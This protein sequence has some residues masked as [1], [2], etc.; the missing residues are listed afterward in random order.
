VTHARRPELGSPDDHRERT[1]R[2]LGWSVSGQLAA[3]AVRVGFGVTLARLLSPRD[4]GLLA[5]ILVFS[6]FAIAIADFGLEEALVHRR[7]LRERH[8]SSVFWGAVL[9]GCVLSLVTAAGAPWIAAFY[10]VPDLRGLALLL[11]PFFVLRGIGTVPRA[12]VARRLDFRTIARIDATSATIAGSCA[13]ALAWLGFG[14]VS[15]VVQLLAAAVVES[16][17]VLRTSAWRPRAQLRPAAIRELLG[18]GGWRVATRALGHWSVNVDQLLVGRLLGAGLL[19]AYTR[20]SN[21]VRSP[22]LYVSRPIARAM[23]PS[24]SLI[25]HEPGRVRSAYLRSSGGSAL[26]T[27]PLCLGLFACAEPLVLGV[28]G[29]QWRETVPLVRI[30]SIAGLIQSVT[31]LSSSVFLSQGRPA[32]HLL[33]N[34]FQSVMVVGAVLIGRRWSIEGVAAGYVVANAACAVPTLHVAGRLV[35]FRAGDVLRPLLPVLGSAV[36]M[37]LAVLALGALVGPRL[38]ALVLL[39]IQVAAGAAVYW[40]ALRALG[41]EPYAEV[42][43]LLRRAR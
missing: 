37:A 19:G 38:P 32:L 30:L 1:L 26:A 36:V 24:L 20:A 42:L 43:V 25:Q 11:A 40:G 23:F 34:V 17:L 7:D 3:Q 13:V 35:G 27:F 31:T 33:M 21:L 18:F 14:A 5:M 12:L 10:D 6:Q 9:S 8:R 4:F 41:A 2:A 22:V 28:L 15:L 39:A 29:P 16:V